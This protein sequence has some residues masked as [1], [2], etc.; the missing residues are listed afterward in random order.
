[1]ARFKLRSVA[2][3]WSAQVAEPVDGLPYLG[4]N[5]L[6]KHVYVGTGYSG[7]GMTFGTLAAM[8]ASDLILE[9][10]N[11]WARLFDATRVKPLAAAREFVAENVDFPAHLVGDRLKKA[12]AE[13]L[14]AVSPGE[15]KIVELGVGKVAVYRDEAGAV[16]AVDPVCTHLKC[17]VEFNAAEKS[18]DCP[19][20]GSRFTT[21]GQVINGPAVKDL[22]RI[23]L[24]TMP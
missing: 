6:S 23:S 16:H 24:E 20:H 13:S 12:E 3:R 2:Y 15:G 19:C 4:R 7:T 9:R 1:M 11:P 22:E 21:D 18:W 8:I 17:R 5:S 14:R 10:E